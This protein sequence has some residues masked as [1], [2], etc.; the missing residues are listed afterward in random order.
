MRSGKR[1]H[2][3]ALRNS[4]VS[5][6]STLSCGEIAPTYRSKEKDRVTTRKPSQRMICPPQGAHHLTFFDIYLWSDENSPPSSYIIAGRANF[7]RLYGP[8]SGGPI[9]SLFA[10][11]DKPAACITQVMLRP[12][13]NA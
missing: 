2:K 5:H 11:I 12:S 7:A 6:G 3:H 13:R 9:F 1:C 4:H 10:S 8:A